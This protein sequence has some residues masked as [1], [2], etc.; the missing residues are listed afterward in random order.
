[1]SYDGN[2]VIAHSAA[3]QHRRN[4]ENETE[5]FEKQKTKSLLSCNNFLP[6][7]NTL[8]RSKR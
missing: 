4:N 5:K 6:D 8:H 3:Q 2:T 7:R 1:M